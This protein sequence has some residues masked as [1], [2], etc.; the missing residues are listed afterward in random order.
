MKKVIY[1]C[2][3]VRIGIFGLSP[4]IL[5]F[6]LYFIALLYIPAGKVQHFLAFLCGI[7]V[8][9]S[10][11]FAPYYIIPREKELEEEKN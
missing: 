8:T 5:S 7:G 11:I 1:I 9:F 10:I 6:S 4:M 2:K 3:R